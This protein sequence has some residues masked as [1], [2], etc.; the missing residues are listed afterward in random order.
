MLG[1]GCAG[2]PV[3]GVGDPAARA[4]EPVAP[5]RSAA[6]SAVLR[7]FAAGRTAARTPAR[8]S[9]RPVRAALQPLAPGLDV[10]EPVTPHR[11]A[12]AATTV[13]ALGAAS[14]PSSPTRSRVDLV[15]G[16][17]SSRCAA[18]SSTS[19]RRPRSTRSGSSSGATSV[20]E[21]RTFSVADQRTAPR[22]SSGCGLPPCRELLLTEEVR[23]RA[24]ARPPS[25]RELARAR[26]TRSPRASPWRAWSRSPRLLVDETWSCSLDLLARRHPRGRPATPSASRTRAHDLVATNEEF[27]EASWAARGRR[28]HGPDRPR[29]AASWPLLGRRT[30]PHARAPAQALVDRQPVRLRRRRSTVVERR[31]RR[32]AVAC[33]RQPADAYHGEIE[34]GDH[35]H[36]ALARRRLA[37]SSWSP[38]VTAPRS[39]AVEVLARARARRRALVEEVPAAPAPGV[40]HRSP[41]AR[42]RRGFVDDG[43][44]L[45]AAHRRGRLGGQPALHPRH[46]QDAASR[47]A[48]PIDPLELQRRRLRRARAARHRPV[49]R[50]D[51]ARGPGAR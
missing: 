35:G 10:L 6:A 46:A 41:A 31:R 36:R 9:S 39:G 42:L 1:A 32:A 13:A 27:L 18:A 23:E 11:R 4:A 40:V 16:A 2:A 14:S 37:A 38:R 43:A 21:I 7:G 20:E 48:T 22:R 29:R 30:R 49:R 15:A 51:A 8:A 34:R 28:R 24:A 12:R 17:A 3:P 50:A 19:S 45:V 5:R 47:G 33:P 25:T 44:R 26:S